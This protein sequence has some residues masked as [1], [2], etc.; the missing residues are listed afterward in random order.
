[1]LGSAVRALKM[2]GGG[3]PVTAGKPLDQLYRTENTDL[4]T[5]G[6]CNLARHIANAR[7]YGVPVVV[8][9]NKFASD[10]PAELEAVRQAALQAGARSALRE[11]LHSSVRLCGSL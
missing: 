1:M 7:K 8:A 9:I 10:T 5:A 6:C 4:V 3:P 11:P 2:H